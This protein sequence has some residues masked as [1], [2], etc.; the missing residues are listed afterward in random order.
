MYIYIYWTKTYKMNCL[1]LLSLYII[2]FGCVGSL[3][4]ILTF[5]NIL[6]VRLAPWSF[7]KLEYPIGVLGTSLFIP[8]CLRPEA[9][10][11]HQ[12]LYVII[13]G[14]HEAFVHSPKSPKG[15]SLPH[16]APFHPSQVYR[17]PLF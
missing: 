16:A 17:E 11:C 13:L 1:F 15:L 8:L 7:A 10:T 4:V 9:R 5:F 6:E 2:L 3:M 12:L 14:W